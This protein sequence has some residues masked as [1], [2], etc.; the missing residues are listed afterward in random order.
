MCLAFLFG[1]KSN[2]YKGGKKAQVVLPKRGSAENGLQ[3]NFICSVCAGWAGLTFTEWIKAF[4]TQ[5]GL[6]EQLRQHTQ[7]PQCLCRANPGKQETGKG[8]EHRAREQGL[9][10]TPSMDSSTACHAELS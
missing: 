1:E 9:P 4:S 10:C 2:I 7:T 5:P 6:C 8:H 3:G